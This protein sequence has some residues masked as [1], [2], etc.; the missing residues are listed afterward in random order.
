M[1]G[2][3]RVKMSLYQAKRTLSALDKIGANVDAVRL[4]SHLAGVEIAKK[5]REVKTLSKA[6]RE[7]A[8]AVVEGKGA[9]YPAKVKLE[10]LESV[11]KEYTSLK[12]PDVLKALLSALDVWSPAYLH[13]VVGV[14]HL[15]G[16]GCGRAACSVESKSTLPIRTPQIERCFCFCYPHMWDTARGSCLSG[17]RVVLR[18]VWCDK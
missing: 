1:A 12:D 7:H 9:E 6:D 10:I 4:R 16:R 14:V 17:Q 13:V 15:V 5:L 18:A 11:C 2:K 3:E 8:C